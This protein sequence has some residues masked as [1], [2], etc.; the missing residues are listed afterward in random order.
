MRG[1]RKGR[2]PAPWRC[3]R[4]QGAV[5]PRTCV[6]SFGP[7]GQQCPFGGPAEGS[8]RQSLC[9][10]GPPEEQVS[11]PANPRGLGPPRLE[12]CHPRKEGLEDWGPLPSTLP[13][14][15]GL[16]VFGVPRPVSPLAGKYKRRGLEPI[17]WLGGRSPLG[18][19]GQV[20][21]AP[22]STRIRPTGRLLSKSGRGGCG[23]SGTPPE[24]ILG[25]G[26][27]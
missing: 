14:A 12:S 16:G 22:Q 17:L 25:L 18:C 27:L 2:W 23:L 24:S 26:L 11:P 19:S 5:T 1:G 7:A 6:L 3:L 9:V 4:L 15:V 13:F 10:L 20:G 21:P 8:D